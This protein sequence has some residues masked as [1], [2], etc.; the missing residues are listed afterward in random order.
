MDCTHSGYGGGYPC[1]AVQHVVAVDKPS[2][3][4]ASIYGAHGNEV[5]HDIVVGVIVDGS[6]CAAN[7]FPAAPGMTGQTSASCSRW[8]PA[9][10]SVIT[11]YVTGSTGIA[12]RPGVT[13]IGG[14]LVI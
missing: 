3:I 8:V 4:V 9:G 1:R 6:H 10:T 11:I 14:V 2:A 7:R 12:V 13:L 5:G